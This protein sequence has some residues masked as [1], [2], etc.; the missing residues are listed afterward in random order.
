PPEGARVR[1]RLD[2]PRGRDR[3]G[4]RA[5]P[6]ERPH[7]RGLRRPGARRVRGHARRRGALL[8]L[9]RDRHGH[10][11]ER[12]RARAG[13]HRRDRGAEARVAASD[14]A[15]LTSFALTEP[16]AGSDVSGIQTTAVRDG[17]EYIVNGSTMFITN[18]G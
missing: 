9:L 18:A 12:A 8:G 13:D 6:D 15:L 1:R 14:R 5:R 2:P 10:R 11:G 16:N 7:S 3:E 17:D 4:P